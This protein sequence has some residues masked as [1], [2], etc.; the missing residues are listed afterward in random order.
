MPRPPRSPSWLNPGVA[1]EGAIAQSQAP[2]GAGV[3]EDQPPLRFGRG[4]RPDAE[5]EPE[6]EDEFVP[7][8]QRDVLMDASFGKALVSSS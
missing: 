4:E 2:T 8:R 6:S 7:G 3:E 1:L 5:D